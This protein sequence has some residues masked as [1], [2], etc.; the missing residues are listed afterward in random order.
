M[1]P[2]TDARLTSL[3]RHI[4]HVQE[5]CRIIAERLMAGGE[6]ALGLALMANAQV[7]DNSKFRGVEWLYLND[8]AWPRDADDEAFRLAL[9]QHVT[10]NAHHPEY[11]GGIEEMPRVF[12]AE[13]TADWKAR[14]NEM[15]TDLLEWVKEKATARFGFST[16]GRVYK[17][18]KSF[19][20]ILLERKFT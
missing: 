15:G 9:R 11:W 4:S 19:T 7:H 18:I 10:T 13:M 3:L 14:S 20:D 5:N 1:D 16:S 6:E 12:L 2:R 17:E 8:G